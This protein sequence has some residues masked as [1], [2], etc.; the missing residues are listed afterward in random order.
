MRKTNHPGAQRYFQ[1]LGFEATELEVCGSGLEDLH[2]SSN[3]L[4]DSTWANV[5]NII[6]LVLRLSREFEGMIHNI[7]CHHIRNF[8]IPAT[9]S[10]P[11]IPDVKRTSKS[12]AIS[13]GIVRC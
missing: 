3:V 10:N 9:P 13:C 6:L 8:I 1:Q 11:S 2:V 5:A 4:G 12:F 7:P